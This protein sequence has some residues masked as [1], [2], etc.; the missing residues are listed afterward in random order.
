MVPSASRSVVINRPIAELFAF[1]ADAENDPRWRSGVREIKRHGEL[2]VG[3]RY[4][5]RRTGPQDER[6][7][8][9]SR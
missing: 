7:P 4:H 9:T 5:Q 3:T 6:S 1:F 2:G 8:R